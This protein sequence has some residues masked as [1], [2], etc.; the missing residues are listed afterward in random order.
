MAQEEMNAIVV[1]QYGEL[2]NL[3]H[4]RVPKPSAPKGWDILVR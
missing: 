2:Q 3:V 4:K 1:E